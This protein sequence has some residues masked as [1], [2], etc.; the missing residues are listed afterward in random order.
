MHQE[1]ITRFQS[2][3]AH[4]AVIGLGYVGLP[5]AVSFAEAG[6]RVTGIDLDRRKV[7]AI[8]SGESYIEDVP[9]TVVRALVTNT[10]G[11]NPL[12]S[13]H[14]S[15]CATSDFGVLADCDAVSIC[16]PT[17]LSKT[18]D[19]DMSYIGSTAEVAR[20]LHAVMVIVL[21]STTYPGTTTE[22]VLPILTQTSQETADATRKSHRP[23]CTGH[24]SPSAKTFFW[25]SHPNGSTPAAPIDDGQHAKGNG[26]R[27][28]RCLEVALAYYGQAID[29]LVPVSSPAAAEMVKPLKIPSAWL[30][31]GW[32][33]SCCSCVTSWGSTPGRCSTPPPPSPLAL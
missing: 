30:T 10:N 28:P 4:V 26:R 23:L 31:L 8:N 12:P 18:G 7:A 13:F 11:S 15:L 33:T 27:Y 20:Y 9:S 22:V 21:E 16:V 24:R 5:L 25:R 17:P 29:T 3:Q 1:I 14:G 19:P 6:Y 32:P 2:R